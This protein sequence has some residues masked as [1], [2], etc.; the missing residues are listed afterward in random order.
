MHPTTG[1]WRPPTPLRWS[2]RRT[3][4]PGMPTGGRS[5]RRTGSASPDLDRGRQVSTLSG[6]ERTRLALAALMV[7]RPACV[8]LDEPTN[9]LDEPAMELL[10]DFLIALPG[11]VVVAS[12]DRMFLDRVCTDIVDLDPTALGTDGRGGRRFGGGFSRYL[13]VQADARTRWERTYLEQQQE[14]AELR[15][16]AAI[17][18]SAIAHNRGP[19]DND[20]FIYQFKGPRWTG[21]LSRRVHDAARRLAIAERAR[22]ASRRQTLQF[23]GRFAGAPPEPTAPRQPS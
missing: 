3:T 15:R 5:L 9:H 6:G 18:T 20:K 21:Q 22:S 11:I 4:T 23:T 13:D 7:T 10:E 12:H 1:H 17:D 19:R 14:I 2:G 8:L 16:Q